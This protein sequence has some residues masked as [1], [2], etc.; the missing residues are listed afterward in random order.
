LLLTEAAKGIKSSNPY[1]KSKRILLRQKGQNP[2][3]IAYADK[4]SKSIKALMWH[5]ENSSKKNR[6]VAT[7]A[8]ARE[9]S[10]FV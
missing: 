5:L 2:E 1:K 9:L 4:G 7:T 3:T 8:G 6:N 10:C